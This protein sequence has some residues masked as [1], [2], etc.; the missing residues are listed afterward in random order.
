MSGDTFD[1]INRPIMPN[2]A[3]IPNMINPQQ[4][5]EQQY[6]QSPETNYYQQQQ[7][8][9]TSQPKFDDE[10]TVTIGGFH[11]TTVPDNEVGGKND[12]MTINTEDVNLTDIVPVQKKRKKNKTETVNSNEIVR[13]ADN[14]DTII[15]TPTINSYF[16]TAT[17]I[18]N[19]MDQ[20]DMVASEVKSELDAV[21]NSRTMKSKYNVMVGLSGNLS[22]LLEAKISAIK[23][24]NNCITKSNDMDYRREKDRKDAAAGAADDKTVMDLYQAIVAGSGFTTP[25]QQQAAVPMSGNSSIANMVR[26]GSDVAP[27]MDPGYYNYM[28]NIT[29]EMNSMLYDQN[30]DVKQCVIFDASTGAKWFQ[31]MNTKTGQPIPNAPAHDQM[32]LEDTV[33]DLKNKIAKNSNLNETYPLVILNAGVTSE[34]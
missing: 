20:I 34:Y 4:T 29:P 28:A 8:M 17:M 9:Y 21:R 2:T 5:Y 3:P 24:L 32:F 31:V 11:F 16:E 10:P 7:Q 30:P 14:S 33:L 1:F 18:K 6:M 15:E 25:S 22:E 26:G 12:K 27:Q 23:E 13:P 19:T